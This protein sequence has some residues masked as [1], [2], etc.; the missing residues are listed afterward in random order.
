MFEVQVQGRFKK[1][2]EGDLYISLEIT[3]KM[4]LGLLTKVRQTCMYTYVPLEGSRKPDPGS[5]ANDLEA[6]LDR[7]A[8]VIWGRHLWRSKVCSW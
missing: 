1:E 2:P 3:Q 4:K 8:V 6:R 5:W 7:L